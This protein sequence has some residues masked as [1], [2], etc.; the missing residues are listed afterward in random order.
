[1]PVVSN[2]SPILNLALIDRLSLVEEQFGKVL[3]TKAVLDELRVEENLPGSRLMKNALDSGWIQV[4]EVHDSPILRILNR[5]LDKGEAEAIALALELK[6]EMIL[7]D[8]REAR[9][10]AKDLELSVTGVLGILLRA[11]HQKR[12]PSLQHELKMLRNEAG[13]RIA[14]HLYN[15]ILQN[16][17]DMD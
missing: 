12:I 1:M 2:T 8:E 17:K 4:A 16:I 10:A 15:K 7:L 11:W 13:F 5:D 3:I 6:A 14:D 9:M